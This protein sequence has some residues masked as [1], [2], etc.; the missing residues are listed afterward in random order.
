EELEGRFPDFDDFL[1]QL[2][3]KR[4]EI[5]SAFESKKV[6]LQEA[7]NKRA[8][9]LQQAAD[10]ILKAVQNR[11]AKLTSVQEINGYFASDLMIEKVRATVEELLQ[12][13]DTVKAD[14]IQ[15]R[16][17][18]VKEDAIR[19]LKDRHELFEDGENIL[20]FGKFRFTVNTQP[21]E[22]SIV[23]RDDAMFY[24]LTGTSFFE[25]IN[26]EKFLNY[27][28]VWEQTLVSENGQ[29]Y[30]A[31]Y[32]AFQ[33]LQAAQEKRAQ[34]QEENEIILSLDELHKLTLAELTEYVQKF[35]A[36]R[37]S[38]GYIKGVHDH[39]AALILASLVRLIKTADLLR[40]DA[41]SR[42]C[43]QLFWTCFAKN[44]RKTLLNHQLKGVGAILQVFPETHQ[45]DA[46]I[47]DLQHDIQEFVS[48]TG[49][50]P[51]ADTASAGEYLFY[52]LTR[53]NQFVIDAQAAA[54]YDGFKHYL[55]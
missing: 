5:Y 18:T 43:A 9:S 50:L 28:P 39:D 49:L 23:H 12:I 24:H 2:T 48:E 4:E 40:Y 6:A 41:I 17:K 34:Q 14:T 8:T 27:R 21:L 1:E 31:E 36:S 26:D 13:G 46:I 25:K 54:L 44:D 22:L 53:G 3:V 16:L 45:F 10:R 37:F 32:L 29:V 11:V 19:Q 20:K 52:E 38:E 35:M 7:R 55:T 51:D 33:V 15:S 30:R 47:Q 42:A